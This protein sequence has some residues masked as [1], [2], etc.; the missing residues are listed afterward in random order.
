MDQGG[1]GGDFQQGGQEDYSQP[2]NQGVKYVCGGKQALSSL[3]R[4]ILVRAV[5]VHAFAPHLG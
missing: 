4:R 1:G 5:C 2:A 3:G